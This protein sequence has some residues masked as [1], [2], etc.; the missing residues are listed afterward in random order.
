[1]DDEQRSTLIEMLR[2]FAEDR[3]LHQT[4]IRD[5]HG[6]HFYQ[7][8]EEA[9]QQRSSEPRGRWRVHFHVPI[10]AERLTIL[11]TTQSEIRQCLEHLQPPDE[12]PLHLEIETYAWTVLPPPLRPPSLAEGISRELIWFRDQFLTEKC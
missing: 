12:Q 5:A 8:L 4:T 7:D 2:Q 9:L 6:Q 11:D 3:Y 1:M 10:F